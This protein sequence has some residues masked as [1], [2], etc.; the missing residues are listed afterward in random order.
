MPKNLKPTDKEPYSR[1]DVL[2]FSLPAIALATIR[3]SGWRARAMVLLLRYTAL[4]ISG[5]ASLA[6]GRVRNGEIYL[7]TM[8]RQS[9]ETASASRVAKGARYRS[10]PSWC[11]R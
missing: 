9:G 6:K 7:R 1:N 3:T 4:R 10:S 2:G 11:Q 5:A 8:K